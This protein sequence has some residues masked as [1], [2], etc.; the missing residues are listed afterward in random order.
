HRAV[1]AFT[2]RHLEYVIQHAVVTSEEFGIMRIAG[3]GIGDHEN[4]YTDGARAEHPRYLS[5]VCCPGI[6]REVHQRFLACLVTFGNEYFRRVNHRLIVRHVENGCDTASRSCTRP[7][8]EILLVSE[9]R[10]AKVHM[11]IDEAGKDNL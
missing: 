7:S 8:G 1:G 11:S 10:I 3:F 6:K 5:K 4:L 2:L 9:A